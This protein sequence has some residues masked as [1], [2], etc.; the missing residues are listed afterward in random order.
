MQVSERTSCRLPLRGLWSRCMPPRI[1]VVAAMIEK[2]GKYLITQRRPT[3]VLPLLWEFPGGK[4]EEGESDEAALRREIRE[5]LEADVQ[6][7]ELISY[8]RHPY[9]HYTVDLL[10]YQCRLL[11][12][13]L[14]ARAV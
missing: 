8:V 14:Q 12:E 10:L 4:V 3:A 2:D 6:V 13:K 1:R 5:R 11:S 9:D 7:G